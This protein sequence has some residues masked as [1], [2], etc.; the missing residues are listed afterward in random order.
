[1]KIDLK[2]ITI[3]EL[4][5]GFVDSAERASSRTAASSTFVR[6]ISGS[7]STRTSSAMR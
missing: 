5:D 3:K 6:R 2:E 7:S 1:M 4:T